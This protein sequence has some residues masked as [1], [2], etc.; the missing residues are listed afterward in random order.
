MLK[1]MKG[2]KEEFSTSMRVVEGQHSLEDLGR[3]HSNSIVTCNG[4]KYLLRGRAVVGRK[5]GKI[6]IEARDLSKPEPTARHYLPFEKIDNKFPEV[7]YYNV[8]A[9][10][11][12]RAIFV[13][14]ITSQ[15]QWR[16]GFHESIARISTPFVPKV[17]DAL[18]FFFSD[19]RQINQDYST[20]LMV[21]S[22]CSDNYLQLDEAL[23]TISR[24]HAISAALSK[25]V[26][27]SLSPYDNSIGVFLMGV[28]VGSIDPSNGQ[29]HIF[30]EWAEDS[31]KEVC[32][33]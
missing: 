22:Q 17:A 12:T 28:E 27:I 15:R 13:D 11:P 14:R 21:Y 5:T 4:K 18:H 25:K 20:T 30:Q 19:I 32:N 24:N 23:H 16:Y 7:G 29:V 26:A 31:I 2:W 10:T 3:L 6:Y 33:A 1:T 8:S 9:L